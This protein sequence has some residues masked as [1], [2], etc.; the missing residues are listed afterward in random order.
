M[1]CDYCRVDA[2]TPGMLRCPHCG[3]AVTSP[4]PEPPS[5]SPQPLACGMAMVMSMADEPVMEQQLLLSTGSIDV[6]EYNPPPSVTLDGH[7]RMSAE[8]RF[9]R[10]TRHAVCCSDYMEHTRCQADD[11]DERQL[12][13]SKD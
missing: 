11:D 1:K 12:W 9:W 6:G 3:M 4:A 10:H 13:E 5:T 2:V 7:M 8:A